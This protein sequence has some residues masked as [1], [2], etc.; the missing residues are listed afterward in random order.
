MSIYPLSESFSDQLKA[1]RTMA[2]AAGSSTS[3]EHLCQRVLDELVAILDFDIGCIRMLADNHKTLNVSAVSG[4]QKEWIRGLLLPQ[5]IDDPYFVASWVAKHRTPI[6]APDVFQ[7]PIFDSHGDRLKEIGIRA[8]IS[9][10]IIDSEDHLFGILH[11]LGFAPVVLTD[12]DRQFFDTLACMLALLI[13]Q[14]QIE[15]AL[16][17]SE[18]NYRSIFNNIQ[19]TFFRVNLDGILAMINPSGVH[20][21]GYKSADEL[22]GKPVAE[23]VYY[24]PEDRSIYLDILNKQGYIKDLD[25]PLRRK[26]GSRIMLEINAYF[27]RDENGRPIAMEGILRDVRQ[28]KILE[29]E[30]M[31]AQKMESIGLLAGGLAHDFNNILTAIMGNIS[32]AR[33]LLPE[34]SR[35]TLRLQKAEDACLRARDINQQ[36]L[37]FSKGGR[38]I[39]QLADIGKLLHQIIG[40]SLRGRDVRCELTIQEDLWPVMIDEGQISQAIHNLVINA[41]QAMPEGG[42][43]FV[44]ARNVSLEHS[45][46]KKAEPEVLIEVIDSGN[47][48]DPDTVTKA[49]DPYFSTKPNGSGLGLTT[50]YSIIQNHDGRISIQSQVGTGTTVSIRLPA[51]LGQVPVS[52]QSSISLNPIGGRLLIMDDDLSILEMARTLCSEINLELLEA[53]D[54]HSAIRQYTE[55]LHANHPIDLVIIDLIIPGGIGG[56]E[57]I[58]QLSAIDPGIRAIVSSGYSND[59]VMANYTEHGFIDCLRKPFQIDDLYRIIAKWIKQPQGED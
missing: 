36:L 23:T 16:R 29:Q 12:S 28:R 18:E 11:L 43:L 25:I 54:S 56:K 26:D 24:N 48:M 3:M 30:L 34:D 13:R 8:L 27:R 55:A 1:F 57:T 40:F 15:T 14:T 52:E 44:T 6:F 47:G 33:K 4:K 39:R 37:T 22:V 32:L 38:P 53:V 2:E 35:A 49:F 7:H 59:P 5:D 45:V 17:I 21:L 58:S 31:K 51:Q 10:P 9:W 50:V 42:S 20:L 46:L 41:V 19:D